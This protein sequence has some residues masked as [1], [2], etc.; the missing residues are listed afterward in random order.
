MACAC[1]VVCMS[2]MWRPIRGECPSCRT[3]SKRSLHVF[4]SFGMN[5]SAIVEKLNLK[6]NGYVDEIKGPRDE[7]L[8]IY[9]SPIVRGAININIYVNR[10]ERF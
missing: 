3:R 1:C 6:L 7:I 10:A 8:N 5:E 9:C 2:C 4:S